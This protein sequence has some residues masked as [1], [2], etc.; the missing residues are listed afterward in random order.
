VDCDLS[1]YEYEFTIPDYTR[2]EFYDN[3]MERTNDKADENIVRTLANNAGPTV[4]WLTEQGVT[5]DMDPLAVGY[6]V[7]RT[8]FDGEE[9]V[10]TLVETAE[11][12]GADVF[13][14][15]EVR[16]LLFDEIRITG[17]EAVVDD[18]RHTFDCDAVILASG[19]FE[20]SSQKSL[21]GGRVRR[22]E[23]PRESLQYR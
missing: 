6:T 9:A 22:H 20:S 18:D 21:H 17:I 11:E 15:A 4:K 2:D 23:G 1:E 8:W 14:E 10:A 12:Y 3:I 7:A 19:G 13:Y 16:E 5:W